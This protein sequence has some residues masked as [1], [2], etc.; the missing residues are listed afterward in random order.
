MCMRD[1]LIVCARERRKERSGGRK[2]HGRRKRFPRDFLLLLSSSSEGKK[3]HTHTHEF[4]M[5]KGA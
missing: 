2:V 3:T 1:T 5:N 4:H